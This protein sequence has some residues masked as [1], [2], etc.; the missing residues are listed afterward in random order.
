MI[1]LSHVR[2]GGE[3]VPWDCSME[4]DRV[5]S[6]LLPDVYAKTRRKGDADRLEQ[7]V[8]IAGLELCANL[9]RM[10]SSTVC[11]H[12]LLQPIG[13]SISPTLITKSKL[14]K[15]LHGFDP[16]DARHLCLSTLKLPFTELELRN[17]L[18]PQKPFC[19][20]E[21]QP[22]SRRSQATAGVAGRLLLLGGGGLG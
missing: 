16:L 9:R 2:S 4:M 15:K 1:G 14:P 21:L 5:F 3:I 8:A 6:L 17:H 22:R 20:N 10:A 7:L 11:V 19:S 18:V 13:C 12:K